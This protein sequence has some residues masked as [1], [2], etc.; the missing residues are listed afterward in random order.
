MKK[1]IAFSGSNSSQ[2]INQQLIEATSGLL[3]GVEVEILN[4]RNY[5]APVYGIDLEMSEG[6]PGTMKSLKEKMSG[7]DG[8]LVSTPEHNGSMPAVLK[9]T[10]DWLSRM[11]QKA[12][13][14]KPTVF[15]STSPGP[16]GGMSALEHLVAIM[17][18]RGAII[19]G[20]YSLG[21]FGDHLKD[22]NLTKEKASEL[23]PILDKLSDAVNK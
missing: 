6:F 20:S 15:M 14:E 21:N 19:V 10:I 3:D 7:A 13:Q 5:P 1:I 16:R 23:K 17:P 11:D 18:F 9:N 4:L 2:S 8:F 12:F 22:G